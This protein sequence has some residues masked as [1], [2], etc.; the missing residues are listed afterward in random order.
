MCWGGEGGAEINREGR[1]RENECNNQ[2]IRETER[3][4]RRKARG[5]RE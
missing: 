5:D 3:R 1:E 4:E 2:P